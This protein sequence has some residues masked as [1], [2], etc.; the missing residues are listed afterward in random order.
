MHCA[1]T[2]AGRWCQFGL[3]VLQALNTVDCAPILRHA[4]MLIPPYQNIRT[5]H[6]F[7]NH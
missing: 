1:A 7:F 3:Q 4:A 6:A 2:K 5:A